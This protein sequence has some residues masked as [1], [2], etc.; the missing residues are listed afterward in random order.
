MRG[1]E[2]SLDDVLLD[3]LLLTSTTGQL[4]ESASDHQQQQ[5]RRRCAT[6]KLTTARCLSFVF[7]LPLI[8]QHSLTLSDHTVAPALRHM[9]NLFVN[10]AFPT[11]FRDV[12][13]PVRMLDRLERCGG[14]AVA[15][16]VAWSRGRVLCQ[17][18]GFA[19]FGRSGNSGVRSRGARVI[20]L[21]FTCVG[22]VRPA[23]EGHAV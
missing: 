3:D 5:V 10:S 13:T 12:V 19:G 20:T 18:G 15:Y 2:F 1:D 16:I 9:S 7:G 11:D 22:D 17:S 4:K 6:A 8:F 23:S 21:R 14:V